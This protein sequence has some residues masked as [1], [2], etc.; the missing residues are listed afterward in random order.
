MTSRLSSAVILSAKVGDSFVRAMSERD[1]LLTQIVQVIG[2]GEVR[3]DLMLLDARI[4]V[5]P[6]WSLIL[7]F[8][9]LGLQEIFERQ[10]QES[11]AARPL[12]FATLQ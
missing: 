2:H 12:L 8:Q 11:A 7:G 5:K 6:C 3:S 10:E 4:G 1:V 9:G